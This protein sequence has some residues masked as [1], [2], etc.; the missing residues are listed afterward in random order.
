MRIQMTLLMLCVLWRIY[1]VKGHTVLTTSTPTAFDGELYTLICRKFPMDLRDVSWFRDGTRV[2]VTQGSSTIYNIDSSVKNSFR[3]GRINV[4]CHALQHN[5]TIRINSSIDNGT[6]WWCKGLTTSNKLMIYIEGKPLGATTTRATDVSSFTT[7]DTISTTTKC[8]PRDTS[9]EII[10]LVAASVG[11]TVA[12]S[13]LTVVILITCFKHCRTRG[14]NTAN[15]Y[16]SISAREDMEHLY[17]PVQG[18]VEAPNYANTPVSNAVNDVPV[19]A[20]TGDEQYYSFVGITDAE[21]N[22]IRI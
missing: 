14:V 11:G 8:P 20:D 19:A 3:S 9:R 4:Y 2:F 1:K 12:G 5:V 15:T 17:S 6:T 22:H 18:G 7:P 13:V 21:R 16:D 10:Y